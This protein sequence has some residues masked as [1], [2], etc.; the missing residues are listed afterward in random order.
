MRYE[1]LLVV[2]L[3]FACQSAL[4]ALPDSTVPGH[5]VQDGVAP[6]TSQPLRLSFRLMLFAFDA[7]DLSARHLQ[8]LDYVKRFITPETQIF[9]RG[10]TDVI[11]NPRRNRELA[12][13][14]CRSVESYLR[15]NTV[16]ADIRLQAVAND[17]ILFRNDSPEGR[18]YSRTVEISIQSPGS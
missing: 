12:L 5:R 9:I 2:G 1:L 10:F 3:I 18:F 17:E 11:G 6:S 13:Q 7:A 15:R 8:T 16:A 4:A 14:R